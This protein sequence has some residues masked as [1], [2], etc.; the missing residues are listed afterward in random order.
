MAGVLSVLVVAVAASYLFREK[1][2]KYSSTG[3]LAG[4]ASIWLLMMPS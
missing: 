2:T 4:V 1:F 3:V